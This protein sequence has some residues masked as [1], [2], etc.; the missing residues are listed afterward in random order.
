MLLQRPS[1]ITFN[2]EQE[3]TGA[4]NEHSSNPPP[5]SRSDKKLKQFQMN[6]YAPFCEPYNLRSTF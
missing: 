3:L 6:F 2:R 1:G 5:K 4:P